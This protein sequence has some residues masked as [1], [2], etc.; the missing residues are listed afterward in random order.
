MVVI[1]VQEIGQVTA[2]KDN[3]LLVFLANV[4][5]T[6]LDVII[7]AKYSPTPPS[8]NSHQHQSFRNLELPFG[9]FGRLCQLQI[10]SLECSTGVGKFLEALPATP[11]MLEQLVIYDGDIK[12]LQ[13]LYHARRPDGKSIID[14]SSLKKIVVMVTRL[15]SLMELFG[16]CRNLYK[17]N[18]LSMSF[19]HLIPSSI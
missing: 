15:D 9:R 12:L 5:T 2:A 4:S 1:Y 11:V 10:C 3:A 16:I 17:I 14:F 19:P 18:L 6:R 8:S 7:R 13:R